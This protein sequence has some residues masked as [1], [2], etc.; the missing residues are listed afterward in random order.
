MLPSWY[1]CASKLQESFRVLEFYMIHAHKC[2]SSHILSRDSFPILAR[3]GRQDAKNL[4]RIAFWL[5]MTLMSAHSVIAYYFVSLYSVVYL[6][7]DDGD[8]GED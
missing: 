6:L 3:E 7:Q 2:P 8:A 1:R 5:R 4:M